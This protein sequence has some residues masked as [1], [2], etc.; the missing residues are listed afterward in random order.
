MGGGGGGGGGGERIDGS[1]LCEAHSSFS[2]TYQ[3]LECSV[4]FVHSPV[5][6]SS[7]PDPYHVS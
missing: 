4:P 5:E 6:V 2:I 3:I 7:H 1:P